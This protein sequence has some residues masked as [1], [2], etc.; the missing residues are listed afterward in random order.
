MPSVLRRLMF[1]VKLHICPF[2]SLSTYTT[3]YIEPWL[4]NY[5]DSDSSNDV[6]IKLNEEQKKTVIDLERISLRE[7]GQQAPS[8]IQNEY[9]PELFQLNNRERQKLFKFLYLKEVYAEQKII[10]REAQASFMQ[11]KQKEREHRIKKG[12]PASSYPG[13]TSYLT[14]IGTRQE[15]HND[16]M[17]FLCALLLNHRLYI[18]CGF[19]EAH[20]PIDLKYLAEQIILG[21]G[22]NKLYDRPFA[23]TLCNF[24]IQSTLATR[25]RERC[26]IDH[27]LLD[28]TDKDIIDCEPLDKMVYLSPQSNCEMKS[29]DPD[30]KYIIGGLVDKPSRPLTFTKC[31]ELGIKCE[32]LPLDR[33]LKFD[34]GTKELTID[35]MINI[36]LSLSS[37]YAE[38][39]KAFKWVPQRKLRH[40]ENEDNWGLSVGLK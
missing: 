28:Y 12:L 37:D 17:K 20:R 39:P 18:D 31:K 40:I 14:H 32:K 36:M 4:K 2:A 24:R 27:L 29:Y 34:G 33:Y 3:E 16:R 22:V 9:W 23:I 38:W 26:P 10:D 35:Q 6:F 1:Q 13:Y 7:C 30:K 21:S 19:E 15:L 25:I 5:L 11:L 8:L